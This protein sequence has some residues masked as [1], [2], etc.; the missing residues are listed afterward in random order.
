MHA[1]AFTTLEAAVRHCVDPVGSAQ[2][3]DPA[4]LASDMQAQYRAD[5]TPAIIAAADPA[6]LESVALTDGEVADLVAFLES[7]SSPTLSVLGLRDVPERVPSGL[8]LAD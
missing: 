1:G 8:P 6:E 4:Q 3:Y 7:L 5:Q 2:T